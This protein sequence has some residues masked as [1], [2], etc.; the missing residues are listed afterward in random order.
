MTTLLLTV[1]G[2][3]LLG[4]LHCAGMCGPLVAFFSGADESTG[5]RRGLA[6]VVY[7]AGRLLG[8]VV[9]GLVAGALGVAV[10]LA[11]SLA[12]VQRVAAVVAGVAMVLWGVGWLLK[13]RGVRLPGGASRAAPP[14]LQLWVSR[15]FA[16]LK[17]RPPVVKALL[18]GLLS[19]LLPCG[20]LWMF[21]VIAASTGSVLAGGLVMTA[22]WAG[23]VPI[24]VTLGLGAQALGGPLR[25]HAPVLTAILLVVLG[26]YAIISRPSPEV[27]IGV[28]QRQPTN[29]ATAAEQAEHHESPCCRK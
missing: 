5:L 9:L 14:R 28:A 2:A 23:T 24:L 19:G 8:Y 25:R 27:T 3:S 17:E 12:G 22:F 7:A 6:Q 10:D 26:L 21:L 16:T 20:W 1:L 13:S 29:A 4:S 18:I 15:L 11:G